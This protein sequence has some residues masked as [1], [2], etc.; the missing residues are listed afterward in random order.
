M[1]TGGQA[2]IQAQ[3]TTL[4]RQE[5]DGNSP[6]RKWGLLL[7]QKAFKESWSD[8]MNKWEEENTRQVVF[9]LVGE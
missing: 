4:M 5:K 9:A 1:K 8:I 2:A 7:S 3:A 6:K